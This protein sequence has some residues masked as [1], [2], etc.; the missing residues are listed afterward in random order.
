MKTPWLRAALALFAVGWGANQFAA[1]LPVYKTHDHASSAEVTLLFGAYAIGIIPALLIVSPISDR[2]GRRRVLRPVLLLSIVATCVLIAGGSHLWLLLLG[3]LLA[4]IASGAAFAPGTAWV[5]E[6]STGAAG[7]GARRA[8]IALSSGFASGPLV[9]GILAQWAP[10]PTV[11]PYAPHLILAA[12]ITV[13]AWNTP[14]PTRAVVTEQEQ[15]SEVVAAL[16]QPTF[17]RRVLPTAP[18]VFGCASVSFAT[19]PVLTHIPGPSIAVG[20]GLAALTLSSGVLLQPFGRRLG[21]AS[22]MLTAGALAGTAGLLIATLMAITGAWWLV[23]PAAIGLGA[24]YG[25]I[26]VGGLTGVESVAQPGDLGTLNAIFYSL[27]Y[28]G[29]AVPYLITLA[30]EHHVSGTAVMLFGAVLLALTIPV[31]LIPD[32][33]TA[34]RS[35]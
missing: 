32:R 10:W 31:V 23:V 25:L 26:L 22:K 9:A 20:G 14:E 29:F 12:V 34:R 27:T 7:T 8:T 33:V 30:L 18:W 35:R 3:R 11:L 2:I 13:I 24:A 21:S 6:L 15:E 17:I 19:L 5:K 16:R 4:G 1:M 28:V